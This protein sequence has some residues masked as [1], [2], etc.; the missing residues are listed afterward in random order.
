MKKLLLILS[1]ILIIASTGYGQVGQL[2]AW[3]FSNPNFNDNFSTVQTAD[4][5]W[6]HSG[7]EVSTLSRGSGLTFSPSGLARGFTSVSNNYVSTTGSVRGLNDYFQITVQAK[8]GFTISLKAIDFKVRRSAA[9]GNAMRWAYSLNG[10][11]FTDIGAADISYTGTDADGLV[12][13]IVDLSGVAA[14]Q[15][16]TSSTQV[17]L[18][19][20]VWGYSTSGG[21]FAFGRYADGN[22][23]P[24]LAVRGDIVQSGVSTLLGWDFNI[25]NAGGATLGN[26]TTL[27]AT[28]VKTELNTANL[29]KNGFGTTTLARGFSALGTVG[30]VK[31]PGEY[32]E[33]DVVPNTPGKYI[34]LSSIDVRLRRTS[35]G[36]TT[37]SWSYSKDGGSFVDIGSPS[38]FLVSDDGIVMPTLDLSSISAL[39]NLT[40][41]NSVKF[42]LHAW[43][44]TTTSGTVA[45][46]RA[47]AG[48]VQNSL[49][50]KGTVNDAPLP[51]S[52]TNF[53]AKANK[54]GTVNLAWS[55]SSEQNNSHFEVTRSADGKTFS[56][57]GQVTGAN[58]SSTVK[59]YSYVDG[60]PVAGVN[61]YQLKQVDFDGNSS[62]SKVSFAKVGLG[63]NDLTVGVS[64]NRTSLTANYNASVNGKATFAVY[65][66]SGTKVASV[67]QNV[68]AGNNQVSL[69]VSLGNSLHILKVTQGSESISV[70]F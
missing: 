3:Q 13:P 15:N 24:S 36:A 19:L 66:V 45:I 21:S 18:R 51:V 33:F 1:L 46:G 16:L 25:A 9:G 41:T 5:F 8:T 7:V 59:S 28:Q 34:A 26:E 12:Q 61:Y 47:Y 69:P 64:A 48:Q 32:F 11:D 65:T 27:A 40:N 63:T 20:Y 62:L 43:G 55:T 17:T 53:T 68:I 31:V 50:L 38:T 56:K 6:K 2:L 37:Y 58:N 67:E 57:I 49:E 52:L 42:R 60:N 30:N 70:K 54:Q 35:G 29:T 10:T 23:T 14:L 44:F 4:A 39:T 22:I